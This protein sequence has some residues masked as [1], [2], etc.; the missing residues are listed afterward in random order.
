MH[1]ATNADRHRRALVGSG[2]ANR[3][4]PPPPLRSV[5]ISLSDRK[6]V[7]ECLLG[8]DQAWSRLLDKYKSLVYSIAVRYGAASED[9]ADIFQAVC[10]ELF[11]ELPRLRNTESLRA[12]LVTVTAHKAFHWKRGRM[13]QSN[14]EVRGLEEESLPPLPA[15]GRDLEREQLLREAVGRLPRRDRDMI[16]MLF[17]EDPVRPYTEVARRL[18]LSTGSIGSTRT[19]CL[20][21]L[22]RILEELGF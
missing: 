8:H 13:R 14:R 22:Q 20:R 18:G 3:A 6:L 2:V 1:F 19:R 11:T 7:D 5:P 9:A 15:F 4:T 17:F 12:W 16:Q 10:L 21:R